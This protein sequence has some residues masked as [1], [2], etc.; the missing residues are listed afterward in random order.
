MRIF[1]ASLFPPNRK[2]LGILALRP[3]FIASM[4]TPVEQGDAG[5]NIAIVED[6]PSGV[7]TV[8]DPYLDMLKGDRLT[9]SIEGE[10]ILELIVD[11]ADEGKRLFFHLPK[12]RFNEGWVEDIHFQLLRQGATVAEDSVPLR[13]RVK[14]NRP[15]GVDKEPHKPGH[16][17]LPVPQVPQDVIDNGVTAEWAAKGVPVTIGYYPE[18]A[19]RDTVVLRWGSVRIPR[20]ISESE[21]AGKDPVVILVD[22]DA[23]LAGGDSAALQLNYEVYDEVWNYS[24]DWSRFTAVKVEAGAWRLAAPIIREAVNG[25]IDLIAL[26]PNDVTVTVWVD[27]DPYAEGDFIEFTWVGTPKIGAPL[28]HTESVQIGK[29]PVALDFKVPNADIRAIASGTGDASYVLRKASGEPPQS[30]KRAFARIIGELSEL[31]APL[32]LQAVDGLLDSR[33]EHAW[34]RL[35]PY[36]GMVVGDVVK[37][38]WQGK[39]ADGS[40]YLHE[41]EEDVS[42]NDVDNAI[43]ILV[44]AE[45]IAVLDGGT[46]ELYYRVTDADLNATRESARSYFTVLNLR[47]E[48]PAPVVP[49]ADGD[50]LDPEAIIPNGATVRIEYTD[51]EAGD[52][53]TYYWQSVYANGTVSDWLPVTEASKGRPVSFRIASALVEV[54]R[55][56]TVNVL[57]SLKRGS[58]TRLSNVLQLYIGTPIPVDITNVIDSWGQVA[59][60]GISVDTAVTVT[61]TARVSMGVELLDGDTVLGRAGANDLGVWRFPLMD[62]LPRRYELKAKALYG[63]GTESPVWGF[64]VVTQL[65]P[66]ITRVDDSRGDVADGGATV[67]TAVTL[68]GKASAGLEVEIFEGAQSWGVV[69]V[70]GEGNWRLPRTALAIRGYSLQVRARYGDE[71]ASEVRSFQVVAAVN[72]AITSVMDS[73]GELAEGQTTVDTQIIVS[74]KASIDQPLEV[75]DGQAVLDTVRTD[76]QGNWTLSLSGLAVKVYV[77]KARALYGSGAESAARSF[78]VVDYVF[79]TLDSV[80]DSRGELGDGGATVDTSVTLGGKGSANEQVEIFAGADSKGVARVTASGD[81]T[82]TLSGLAPQTYSVRAKAL[83]GNGEESALRTFTVYVDIKPSITSVSDSRGEVAEA[84]TTVDTS[85][86]LAG[87]ASNSQ[88]VE[89]FDGTTS[90]ATVTANASG[91]WSHSLQGLTV[92]PYRLRAKALYGSGQESDIRSFSVV[93]EVLPTLVSVRDSQGEVGEGGFTFDSRVTLSGKASIGQRIE[94]FEGLVSAGTTAANG[95]G[96]WT[97]IMTGLTIRRYSVKATALYGSGRESAPRTFEVRQGVTPVITRVLDSNGT[98]IGNGGRTYATAVTLHG[99]AQGGLQVQILDNGAAK[100]TLTVPANGT[101]Q[102]ALN[103]LSVGQHDFTAKGLYGSQPVSAPWRVIV[104]SRPPLVIDTSLMLLNGVIYVRADNGQGPSRRPA[105]TSRQRLASGGTPPLRYSS[106]NA[107]VASVDGNGTVMSRANG[108][109]TITVSDS[110]GQSRSYSVTVQNVRRMNL[111]GS[112]QYIVG[113][114]QRLWL[115]ELREIYN[116]YGGGGLA[117]IGWPGGRYWARDQRLVPGFPWPRQQAVFKD[118]NG[119][120]EGWE[121]Q[122]GPLYPGIRIS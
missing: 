3:L 68:S 54:S 64:T 120:G 26:G 116:Q 78:R 63:S 27:G 121:A 42:A 91:D 43:E 87:K 8:I 44:A 88:R 49:E 66:S 93:A 58:Q 101:W 41:V 20:Q 94:V 14:L 115:S 102:A 37:L 12:D 9:V 31:P 72:P 59:D 85:V 103:G 104:D 76:A 99:T 90:L 4:V 35:G 16:S 77:I 105:N 118:M 29:P 53:L 70:D 28:V 100:Q 95:A 13:L 36:P 18:R 7:L 65:I 5:L 71:W 110:A 32:I 75:L 108:S 46:L 6:D 10:R 2:E 112:S 73:R 19:A 69:P 106:S 25:A 97:L 84:G 51:T 48:L 39:R 57:Y 61:G 111:M 47:H 113:G 82:L 30:S 119:G 56:T 60:G 52:V 24:S 55:G 67:D 11:Q 22:Q 92:R 122:I 45:H 1:S 98:A 89:L 34:V 79:P 114:D 62:L 83:Y 109:A 33:L 21:A 86:I 74:G 17:E 15:A 117:Q 40:V 96:D 38:I 80:R 107:N 23:I 81:W 50:V